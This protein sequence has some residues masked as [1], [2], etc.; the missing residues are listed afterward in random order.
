MRIASQQEPVRDI[1]CRFGDGP[2]IARFRLSAGCVAYPE[3]REQDLCWHHARRASPLG[4]Y[5]LIEDYTLLG[6]LRVQDLLKGLW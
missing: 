1:W 6:G 2:A 3:D 5:E 4:S